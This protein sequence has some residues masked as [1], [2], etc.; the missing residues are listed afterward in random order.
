MKLSVYGFLLSSSLLSTHIAFAEN[1]STSPSPGKPTNTSTPALKTNTELN[2]SFD[3][4]KDTQ[5]FTTKSSSNAAGTTYSVNADVSFKNITLVTTASSSSSSSADGN[6]FKNTAG[7]LNFSGDNGSLTFENISLTAQ[8]AAISNTAAGKILQLTNLTNLTFSNSPGSTVTDGKGAIYCEGSD[9]QIINNG[10]VIFSNNHSIENGGAV[11]YKVAPVPPPPPPPSPPPTPPPGTGGLPKAQNTFTFGGNDSL[12]FLGNSSEKNGGAIYAQSL[13]ITS[14]GRTLFTNN[15]A[16]ENG[17]AIAISEDGS[18]SLIAELGDIIFEGNIAKGTPNAIDIG[19]K[20]K[21]EH[22]CALKGQSIIFY[23]PITSNDLADSTSKL[24]INAPLSPPSGGSSSAPITIRSATVLPTAPRLYEGTIIFSGKQQNAPQ[25][26]LLTTANS[27]KQPVELAG[28]TFILEDGVLFSAKS[29]TQTDNNSVVLLEQNTQL[30]ASE[31]IEL[32]NLWVSVTDVNSPDFARVSTTRSTGTVKVTGAITLAVSDPTFYENPDLAKQLD[33]EFIKLSTNGGTITLENSPNTPNQAIP[34]HPGYQGIWQLTWADVPQGSG[35]AKEKVA[36]LGWQPQGY[37]PTAGD[38]KSYTSLVP[39]S[40]WGMVSD[41]AAIQRL[42]EG[43]ANSAQGKDIWGA[44]LSNFLKGKKTDKNRKFRNFSSGYAVG[45]TSQSLHGFKFNFGFCQLFGRAKDYA[46]ARIH[47]KILSGSLYTQYDTELLPI[48]KLLAGTS[49]FRP[50]ILKQITNDFPVTFQ[51]QF[52]YFYGDN[53]MKIKYPDATQTNS[54]WENHCYSGD[55]AT[56][57][58]IPIQ[59]KDGVIQMAS[60]FVKVQNVYVYQ[61]GFHEKGLRRRAF[62]H[63]HLTNISI[64]L[65]LKVYGDS[66]SKNLHYELSAAYVGDA[67]RHNPKNTTT[68]I[69]TNVVTTPWITTATNLERHAARFQA[70][71][72]YAPTSYIQLFAQGSIELRKS[73]R[74]YHANAGSSIHF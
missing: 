50:K 67:Y 34:S 69:V 1:A 47:E 28:G 5:P 31:S 44:G 58:A 51:A 74:S 57:I 14:K 42:I 36:T 53:S 65:G 73:A 30:Q 59:S 8:G 18:I 3:G 27:L 62:D 60:P 13:V 22:L 6:C 41:V 25:T 35:T 52:G 37:L 15:T 24:T 66:A 23:D 61:K 2:Q 68:P 17:G 9:L 40:L 20:A 21:I 56:S 70:G 63:T 16:K 54:S 32:K 71:G 45:A 10:H 19:A 38:T 49:V 7:D 11:C 48:L 12:T 26:K 33:R 4:D 72:D 55:I 46:G 64:P 43:E 39:N 29:F